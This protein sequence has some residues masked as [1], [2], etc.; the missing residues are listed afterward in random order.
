MAKIVIIGAGSGFGGRLSLDVLSR[1]A[2]QGTEI[3][4]C[5]LNE[6]RLDKVYRYVKGT[7]D[8]Y[9][10]PA[11]VRATTDRL[12]VLP[13]A[14]FVVTSVSVGGGAYYGNPYRF[15]IQIPQKYGIEQTVAD[16]MSV[17]ATFRFLRTAPVH[18]QILRDVE[19][20]APNAV[21]LNHTN[22]MSMLSYLHSTQ[23]HLKTV[24][25]CHGI[26]HTNQT[27]CK[28]LGI[29]PEKTR[30]LVA[31]INHLSWFLNWTYEGRNVYDLLRD[32]LADIDNAET[33]EFE[34]K[35]SVRL[36]LY[37]QF[38]YFPTESNG[39]DSEYLPYFRR[40]PELMEWY[41]LS[42]R[43]EVAD[44]RRITQEWMKE[45]E[46]AK[47][48]GEIVRYEEYT[49]GIMEAFITDVP[50][51][52]YGNVMNKGLISNLPQNL[53]VEVPCMADAQGIN[54]VHVG[55]LPTQLAVMNRPQMSIQELG[56]QA[57]VNRD[58]EAAFYAVALDPNVAAVCSLPRIREMFEELWVAE[59]NLLAWFDP[60]HTGPVP[61]ICAP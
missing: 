28:Y 13:D 20:L 8:H 18:M 15:E 11:T 2:L 41:H 27:V 37:R 23:T 9:K 22:P 48:Y 45:G 51:K 17:G 5:D 26:V 53:C 44:S 25:L 6:R 56:V 39:H 24:G 29:E 36:E 32:K 7:I 31:G 33:Q 30:Y 19:R 43:R 16:S 61:E 35:E 55:S 52:F 58:R 14:D 12:E 46:D 10:L 3:C 47:L 40:P 21:H 59:G 38:G 54:P 57:V 34:I 50:F 42:P 49:T 60:S 4:L 1:E